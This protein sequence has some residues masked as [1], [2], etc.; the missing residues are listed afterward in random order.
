M[1]IL[2]MNYFQGAQILM[3]YMNQRCVK[4]T[5]EDM[6]KLLLKDDLEAPLE[7]EKLSS[8]ANTELTG[9]SKLT[10]PISIPSYEKQSHANFTSSPTNYLFELNH[11]QFF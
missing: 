6:T 1:F 10:F 11:S 8:T 2:E 3:E 5:R 9:N 7:I 4:I